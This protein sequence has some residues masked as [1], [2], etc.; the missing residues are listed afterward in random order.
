MPEFRNGVTNDSRDGSALRQ[1]HP[2]KRILI[3]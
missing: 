1:F 3:G 2:S